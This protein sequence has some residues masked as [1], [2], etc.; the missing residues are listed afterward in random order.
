[1]NIFADFVLDVLAGIR[2][3]A[4]TAVLV[5]IRRSAFRMTAAGIPVKDCFMAS[6]IASTLDE[7]AAFPG[8]TDHLGQALYAR[9]QFA[10]W[11]ASFY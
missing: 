11:R 6:A 3:M 2:P 10:A 9:D 7:A 5:S 4:A 8:P 1:M